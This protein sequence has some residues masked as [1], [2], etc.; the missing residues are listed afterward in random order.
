MPRGANKIPQHSEWRS[1]AAAGPPSEPYSLAV[2]IQKLERTSTSGAAAW[3]DAPVSLRVP[4]GPEWLRWQRFPRAAPFAPGPS[5][6]ELRTRVEIIEQW[7]EMLIIMDVHA[8]R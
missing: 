4:F 5:T 7:L 2:V 1:S 3:L 6:A 8:D